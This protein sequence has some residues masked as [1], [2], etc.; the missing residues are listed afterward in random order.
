[1]IVRYTYLSFPD[2]RITPY[3][4]SMAILT[5]FLDKHTVDSVTIAV[6]TMQLLP[7]GE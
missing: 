1:M 7:S 2:D 3:H 6:S 5:N 4:I